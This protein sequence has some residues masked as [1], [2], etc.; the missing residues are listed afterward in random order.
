MQQKLPPQSDKPLAC[1]TTN[2]IAIVIAGQI[3]D[4]ELNIR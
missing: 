2:A 4:V 1:E 3:V